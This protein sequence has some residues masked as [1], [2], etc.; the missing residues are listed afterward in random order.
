MNITVQE[1]AR[2]VEG[3]VSGDGQV[4]I[5]GA[6]ILRDAR[7]GEITLAD[8]D[9][10]SEKLAT[11]PAAAVVIG[12]CYSAPLPLPAIR[13]DEV[14]QSFAKIV[15][16]FHPPRSQRFVGISPAA[17]ISPSARLAPEVQVHPSAVIGDDVEI[18]RGSTIH[19]GVQ[20]MAGCRLAEQVTVF[21]NAVLYENTIVGPRVILHAGVVLGAYGFGYETIDGQHRLSSQLGYVELEADVEVG[22]GSTVDRGTYGATR[23]GAGT[24][25]DNQVMIAHNCRIGRNNL[26][27][28]QVGIA[29]SCV[30]G[31]YV[32]M[33]G[34]VG[35]RD[36]IEVGSGARL[37][38]QSGHMTDVPAKASMLGSP[39]IPDREFWQVQVSV[40]KLTEMRRMLKEL[41]RQ[42]EHLEAV[43][44]KP[45]REAA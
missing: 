26:I 14:H 33:G 18:G 31:D 11:C 35:L 39:A 3:D 21:P 41:H 28:S 19:S 38:A 30:T 42:V 40:R 32:V 1:L 5:Q 17:H 36:H 12:R 4:V 15:T 29:G 43:L 37:G 20:I 9:R 13:V 8:H 6:S 25:I 7:P 10:L 27:C 2:L 16:H 34:Q 22:A 45:N 44:P 24:K 23:I